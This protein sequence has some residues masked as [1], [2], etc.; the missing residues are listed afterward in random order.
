[1]TELKLTPSERAIVRETA[2]IIE[3]DVRVRL[4]DGPMTAAGVKQALTE[5]VDSLMPPVDTAK[6]IV[7]PDPD[8]PGSFRILVP[9]DWIGWLS[10][11]RK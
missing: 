5:S 10:G 2:S 1:M 11:D 7:E 6:F 8:K 9:A 3:A 4:G